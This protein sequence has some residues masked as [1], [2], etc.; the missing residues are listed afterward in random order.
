MTKKTTDELFEMLQSARFENNGQTFRHYKGGVYKIED[1]A[2]RTEDDELDVIYKRIDGPGYDWQAGLED[3]IKFARPMVEF[4][5]EV[6]D[7]DGNSIP[8]FSRIRK[9][10]VWSDEVPSLNN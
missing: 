8:R 6:T 10:D 7:D 9:V 5:G 3:H 4:F 1:F 2:V